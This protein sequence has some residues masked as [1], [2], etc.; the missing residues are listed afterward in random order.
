[1]KSLITAL[2]EKRALRLYFIGI[3]IFIIGLLLPI[4]STVRVLISIIATILS[5]YHVMLEGI[6]DTISWNLR[7]IQNLKSITYF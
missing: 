2:K 3:I 5:G 1:M 4:S 6:D 7:S